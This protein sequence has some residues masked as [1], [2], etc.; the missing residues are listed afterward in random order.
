MVNKI[1]ASDFKQR[2]IQLLTRATYDAVVKDK[3]IVIAVMMSLLKSLT[4]LQSQ[5]F[6]FDM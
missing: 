5:Q 3:Q 4:N 1:K 2:I 6:R